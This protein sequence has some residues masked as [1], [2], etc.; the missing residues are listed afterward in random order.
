MTNYERIK[1]MTINELAEELFKENCDSCPCD[2][3]DYKDNL[4]SISCVKIIKRW[5]ETDS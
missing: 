4:K 1:N 2:K 5:L 3:Y